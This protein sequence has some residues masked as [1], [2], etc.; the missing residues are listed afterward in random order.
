MVHDRLT[1]ITHQTSVAVC[2]ATDTIYTPRPHVIVAII[3]NIMI[4]CYTTARAAFGASAGRRDSLD[5][6]G[7]LSE[8]GPGAED[9]K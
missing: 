8:T 2:P 3:I 9:R 7:M 6:G 5:A 4:R 1:E